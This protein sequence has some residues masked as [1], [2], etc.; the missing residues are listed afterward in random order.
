MSELATYSCYYARIINPNL[1]E[2]ANVSVRLRRLN[3]WGGTTIYPFLLNLYRD[4]DNGRIDSAG[5]AEILSMIESYLVRRLF[6]NVPTN[7]LNRIFIRLYRQLPEA[8]SMVDA[9]REAL[10]APGLRWPADDEFKT[11]MLTYPLFLDSR[12]EQRKLILERLEEDFD[13]KERVDFAPLEIEHIMPQTLTP[14]WRELLDGSEEKHRRLMH[15][16]G[17]LTL[18]GHNPELSNFPFRRKQELYEKSRI[19]MNKEV[20]E[21]SSW[22]EA[23]ILARGQTLAQRAVRLWPGPTR[24]GGT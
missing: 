4:V 11:N 8:A 16:L 7:A 23:E 15:T 9:T 24:D 17:N 18:T 6:A 5:L 10:S 3:R 20:A 14:E 19:A 13:D 22:G 12:P 1:E 2:S 21:T